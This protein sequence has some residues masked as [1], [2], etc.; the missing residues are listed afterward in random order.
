MLL[1][2]GCRL[3]DRALRCERGQYPMPDNGEITCEPAGVLD[4]NTP[5]SCRAVVLGQSHKPRRDIDG[6]RARHLDVVELL[7]HGQP[8]SAGVD[9][10]CLALAAL[11]VLVGADISSG[12][13][14]EVGDG[15]A[16]LHRLYPS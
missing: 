4:Q 7:D 9:L 2:P 1:K 16:L 15:G 13:G 14:A 8:A 5:T 12:G 6:I 3:W 10:Y 11:A